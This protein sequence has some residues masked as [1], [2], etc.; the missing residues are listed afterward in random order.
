ME[1]M[2]F[3]IIDYFDAPVLPEG[4][5]VLR[6]AKVLRKE[7]PSLDI[8][9]YGQLTKM[10]INSLYGIRAELEV[11][12]FMVDIA[13][14]KLAWSGTVTSQIVDPSLTQGTLTSMMSKKLSEA[15][16]NGIKDFLRSEEFRMTISPFL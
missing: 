6:E 16:N 10:E 9:V 15:M 5:T 7:Y 2:E 8:A 1:R 3:V 11:K 13:K 14:E 12:I 4:V